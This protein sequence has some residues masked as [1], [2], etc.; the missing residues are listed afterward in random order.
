MS[1]RF[2]TLFMVLLCSPGFAVAIDEEKQLATQT[3]IAADAAPSPDVQVT[4]APLPDEPAGVVTLR[5]LAASVILNAAAS[6]ADEAE[7]PADTPHG[8]LAEGLARDLSQPPAGERSASWSDRAR[9]QL[10][11][12]A[13]DAAIELFFQVQVAAVENSPTSLQIGRRLPRVT[14]T[15]TSPRGMMNSV[16]YENF[17]AMLEAIPR[18]E[19]DGRILVA[20]QL[21]S[22]SPGTEEEGTPLA[23][24]GEGQQ[25]RAG[26]TETMTLKTTVRAAPGETLVV[27]DQCYH[28]AGKLVEFFVLL[29]AELATAQ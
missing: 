22:S 21:E 13:R 7:V 1:C 23:V 25:V 17:G 11:A 15:T 24:T 28:R 16:T 26:T 18:I 6:H 5:L 8:S 3:E 12:K 27:A 14:G 20:I 9:E 2:A 29:E 19:S 10:D 4:D